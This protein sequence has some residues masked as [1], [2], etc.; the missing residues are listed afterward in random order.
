[1]EEMGKSIEKN[2]FFYLFFYKYCPGFSTLKKIA[3][4]LILI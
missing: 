2:F 4:L 3:I 1:M